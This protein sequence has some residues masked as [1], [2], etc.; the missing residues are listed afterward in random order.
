V[1]ERNGWISLHFGCQNTRNYH[2]RETAS[3][4]PFCHVG[5]TFFLLL[6][7]PFSVFFVNIIYL[8]SSSSSSLVCLLLSTDIP[9]RKLLCSSRPSMNNSNVSTVPSFLDQ[10]ARQ[11]REKGMRVPSFCVVK[12]KYPPKKIEKEKKEVKRRR[13]RRLNRHSIS[14]SCPS[15]LQNYSVVLELSRPFCSIHSVCLSD[16]HS[17][18]IP[19]HLI[20]FVVLYRSAKE[21]TELK[22]VRLATDSSFHCCV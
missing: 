22:A 18:Q 1:Y 13:S 20:Q 19:F 17:K 3:S 10:V 12:I 7:C 14:I 9:I 16:W 2:L 15:G 11:S 6:S 4:Q 21:L 5:F 8:D